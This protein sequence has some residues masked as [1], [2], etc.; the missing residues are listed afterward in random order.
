MSD[1]TQ[2]RPAAA[3]AFELLEPAISLE[4]AAAALRIAP[5]TLRKRAAAAKVPAYKPGRQWVFLPSEIAAYRKASAPKCRSIDVAA[6]RFDSRWRLRK[7]ASKL[8]REIESEHRQL[9]RRRQGGR[10]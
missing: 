10:T 9:L 6:L 8:V 5:S 7:G 2:V 3:S 1:S 4:E